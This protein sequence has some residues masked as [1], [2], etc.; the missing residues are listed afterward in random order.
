[1]LSD[2]DI[3][4]AI[5]EGDLRV[6]PFKKS[7]LRP[8]GI[9]LH[10]GSEILVPVRAGVIDIKAEIS[11]EYDRFEITPSK[12]FIIKPQQFVLGH[13]EEK[14]SIGANIGFLIEGRSTL[15]RIGVSVE[16]SASMVDPGH[17]NRPLTLEIY[18]CGPNSVT[19]YQGMSIGRGVVFR[20]SSKTG[21]PFDGYSRYALQESGVGKPILRLKSESGNSPSSSQKNDL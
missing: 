8:A 11:P 6:D 4:K 16:Q 18:N 2:K 1:M 17:L 3:I 12:P 5:K 14:I 15:A 13:T 21:M 7:S 19:L 20:L 10:L 9:S